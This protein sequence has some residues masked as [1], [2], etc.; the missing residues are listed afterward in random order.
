VSL[1]AAGLFVRSLGEMQRID[2]G[3]PVERLAVVSF[4]VGL[5]GWSQSQGEQF[6]REVRERIA[7]VPGVEAAGL[8]QTGPFQASVMHSVFLEGEEGADNGTLIQVSSVTP[9]YFGAMGLVIRRGRALA[10][11]DRPEAPRVVVVNE[12]M[13]EK[14]WPGQDPI[15]KR[16]HFFREDPVEVVG[17]VRNI[18]YIFPREPPMPYVYQP[19]AQSYVPGINLVVRAE[20]SPGSV[21]PAV[22]RELHAMAPAMPLVVSTGPDRLSNTLW[23]PRAAA[24]LLALFGILA[25]GLAS[26]GLYGVMSY[27]VTQRSRE[28]GVRMALGAQHGDVLRLVLRQGLTVVAVGLVAGLLLALAATR[29]VAGLLFGIT[30]TDPAAFGVTSA[31]LALVAFGATLIPALRAISLSPLLAIRYE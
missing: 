19:L 4:D 29:L 20:R 22:R 21:L 15:G 8:G 7:R 11:T 31:V 2:P 30:P 1:I 9:D 12:T 14:L 17:V 26:V 28:I 24:F 13:A 6:F 10:E 16:F 25:L 3:F 27:A 5:Q 18:K 23:L